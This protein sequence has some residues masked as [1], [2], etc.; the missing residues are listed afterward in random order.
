MVRE[1]FDTREFTAWPIDAL[2]EIQGVV[3]FLCPPP[4]SMLEAKL[5][6]W[7][8]ILGKSLSL[9]EAEKRLHVVSTKDFSTDVLNRQNFLIRVGEEI[10]RSRRTRLPVALLQV[11]V[12]QFGRLTST[13][14][15][16]EAQIVMRTVAQIFQKHSRVNDIIGRMGTD[17]FG[18]LLPH[19]DKQGA[20][21]KGE[22][23]RRMIE[24]ADF[25]KIMRGVGRL[26][27]SVGISEYPTLARDTEELVQTSDDALYQ[28]RSGGNTTCV[29]NAGEGFEPDFVVTPL[30]TGPRAGK[31]P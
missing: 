12:D 10:S 19:T 31:G 2:G 30:V 1:V 27:V 15:L 7:L 22:R 29:A 5:Q 4:S 25:E 3:C 21:I 18:L 13:Y 6:S 14:G 28:V 20:M 9:L 26:T 16:E 24:S 11:A 23:I 8:G 17:E